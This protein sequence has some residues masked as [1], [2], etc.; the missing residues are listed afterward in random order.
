MYK[1]LSF[2]LINLVLQNFA[3]A[4]TEHQQNL[5]VKQPSIIMTRTAKGGKMGEVYINSPV[6][7][8]KEDGEWALV[9]IKAWVKKEGL[10]ATAAANPP[11]PSVAKASDVLIIESFST[12]TVEQGLP[13]KRVYLALKLKNNSS[14]P[15]TS[16]KAILVA[17]AIPIVANDEVLFRESISDDSKTIAPGQT[18]EINFYWEPSEVP[19]QYLKDVTPQTLKLELYQLV[20]E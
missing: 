16:W 20:L 4:Q 9:S 8:E 3:V 12:R 14:A 18:I 17:Q 6:T 11:T 19:F 15:I 2:I 10:G 1:I 13:E 5:I 7:V